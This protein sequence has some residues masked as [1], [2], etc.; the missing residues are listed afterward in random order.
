MIWL[1]SKIS[2]IKSRLKLAISGKEP[3]EPAFLVI[4]IVVAF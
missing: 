3:P 4:D 1:T 2:W